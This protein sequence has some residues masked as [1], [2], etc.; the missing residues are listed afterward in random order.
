MAKEKRVSCIIVTYNRIDYLLKLIDALINQTYAIENIIIVNNKSTDKTVESLIDKKIIN[1]ETLFDTITINEYKGLKVLFYNSSVNTGG[2]GGFRKGFEIAKEIESDYFWVMDDD[3]CPERDCLKNSI[4]SFDKEHLVCV[5][6]RIGE[7]FDDTVVLKYNFS[8][9]FVHLF[10][11]RVSK[12]IKN[13]NKTCEVKTFTFEGPIF[14]KEIMNIVGL[15]N[16][17]YFLQGDDY[18]YA[19]R[20][21]KYTNI[22]Y[23][24]NA[25]IHRQIPCSQKGN[26]DFKL[27]RL[28]YSIR[29]MALLDVRYC[30]NY[31]AKKLR[32]IW[33]K[34][35]WYYVS[36]KQKNPRI[37]VVTKRAIH[38]A[39][40]NIDGKIVELG[41]TF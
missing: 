40:H 4:D 38:D 25:I 11:D 33:L 21:L 15:P 28:Y 34:L 32:P 29:N 37:R 20:C 35:R 7:N 12:E 26:S 24:P 6:K 8:N 22:Y 18:D 1:K 31:F 19:F 36:I 3:I 41:E 16:D 39:C 13:P 23:L 30:S 14:S 9:P 17:K 10:F 27:W 2:A 5:P